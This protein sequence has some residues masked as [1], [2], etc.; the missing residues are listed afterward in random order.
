MKYFYK[1][2]FISLTKFIIDAVT[3]RK[4]IIAVA[5]GFQ[6]WRCV[7]HENGTLVPKYFGDALM[8]FVLFKTTFILY[9]KR[10]TLIYKMNE[11]EN[12]KIN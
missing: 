10:C 11:L 5:N 4:P 7:I 9:N 3:G 2:T 1:P 8:I 12:F 6:K